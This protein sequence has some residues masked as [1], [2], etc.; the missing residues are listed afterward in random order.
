MGVL[1]QPTYAA[2]DT[3]R[4]VIYG[5]GTLLDVQLYNAGT[6]GT[7]TGAD[8]AAITKIVREIAL[9]SGGAC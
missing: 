8:Q 1:R 2:L 5:Y 7:A 4:N 9:G 6:G 3:E